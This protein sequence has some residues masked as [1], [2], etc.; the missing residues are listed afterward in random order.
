VLDDLEFICVKVAALN[1]TIHI[2]AAL[3]YF[4]GGLELLTGGQSA[5]KSILF[6]YLL[7]FARVENAMVLVKSQDTQSSPHTQ[8]Q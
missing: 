1:D 7:N 4:G 3:C 6:I 5:R 2:R 8:W